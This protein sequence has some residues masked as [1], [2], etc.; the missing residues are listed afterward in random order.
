MIRHVSLE[1]ISDGRLYDVNDM[2]KAY[3]DDCKGC[4]DCCMDMGSSI[5]LDPL[6]VCQLTKATGKDFSQ[7]L[8][9]ELEVNV[10]DG[11][12]LPN[13]RMLEGKCPFLNQQGRCSIH[14]SRPGFCRLFPLG[15]VYDEEGFKYFLQINECRRA[16]HT[17]VKVSKWIDMQNLPEYNKYI[18]A[19]HDFQ[20]SISR[21][22][23]SSIEN[24]EED[25]AKNLTM[26]VLQTMYMESYDD[27]RDFYSQ[28]YARMDRIAKMLGV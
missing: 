1:E 10:V 28:A 9:T 21:L 23:I 2:V 3:C 7:L 25:V 13:I 12:V 11:L 4:H 22:I 8:N 14:E 20:K 26:L 15:R 18:Q 19:W 17:K 24:G 5:I 27:G 16:G 6:D